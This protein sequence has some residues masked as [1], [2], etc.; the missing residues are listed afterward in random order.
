MTTKERICTALTGGMS[1]RIP[2]T[3]YRNIAYMEDDLDDLM[4]R[5]M[6]FM[7][8]C[9]VYGARSPNVEMTVEDEVLGGTPTRIVR[10]KTPVGE[11]WQR[12]RT[13]PGYGSSWSVEH[14][15]KRHYWK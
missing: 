15:I 9:H 7:T 6:G 1:D 4:A 2:F 8:S 12:S 14:F 13:E 5:G 10:Y 11:I 3:V